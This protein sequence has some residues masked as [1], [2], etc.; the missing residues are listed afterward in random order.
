MDP[1]PIARLGYSSNLGLQ[2]K[3]QYWVLSHTVLSITV[4]TKKTYSSSTDAVGC[5]TFDQRL[6]EG[7]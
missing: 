5:V 6:H 7:R 3:H 2:S 1:T 4:R